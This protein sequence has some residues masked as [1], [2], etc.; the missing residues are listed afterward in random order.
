MASTKLTLPETTFV[1]DGTKHYDLIRISGPDRLRFLQGQLSCNVEHVNLNQS[2]RGCLCNL[3]GRIITDVRLLAAADEFWMLTPRDMAA[4]LLATLARYQ[5]FYKT[6]LQQVMAPILL[7]ATKHAELSVNDQPVQ[8]PTVQDQ[9]IV[10]PGGII[11]AIDHTDEGWQR[12]V[13]ISTGPQA[14][15]GPLEKMLKDCA[16]MPAGYWHRSNILAGIAHIRPDTQE[17]FTPQLLNYDIN[18]SI[19]FKKGCYTGQEVVA[20]MFYR[21]EA[22]RRLAKVRV[23]NLNSLSEM[24]VNPEQDLVDHVPDQDAQLCLVVATTQAEQRHPDIELFT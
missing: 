7:V 24:G 8:L 16:P 20:R 14:A 11:V 22:K 1:D 12:F 10:V 2:V 9:A 15:Q 6:S 3:K 13:M 4:P 18:G 19:D 17:Q 23:A 21:A 5:V